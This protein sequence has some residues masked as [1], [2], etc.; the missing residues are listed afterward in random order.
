MPKGRFIPLAM[1]IRECSSANAVGKQQVDY[2]NL[3]C[4]MLIQDL[5]KI[6][7]GYEPYP[8]QIRLAN[9]PD[10][11]E[12]L[13]VPTGVGK[14]AATVLT[15]LYRRKFA[16][17]VTR[18]NTPRRLVYCLP[19]R[20]LVE[21]TRD[22][23]AKWIEN[24]ELS[25]K[26]NLGVGVHI[27]L[28]GS[29][30]GDWYEHPEREGILIGTQDMLL[31]RCLNRGYGMSRYLWPV[32]FALLNN[33]CLWVMDETQLMGV[34]LTTSAQ[35]AG[36]RKK[37]RTFGQHHTLWMSATL[38]AKPIVTVDHPLP[39]G[40][41]WKSETIQDDDRKHERV[42]RLL[43][44]AK[45]CEQAEVTL[46]PDNKAG[47]EKQLAELIHAKHVSGTLT[48][49]VMNRVSRAQQVY[50]LLNKIFEKSKSECPEL[51][52][53][54]SR[55]RKA[56]RDLI[57][58]RALDESTIS[59]EGPGRVIIAT[60]AIEA[61]VDVSAT[62]L[63]TELAPWP[64]LVQRFGRC[65]RR[66]SCAVG[67]NAPAQV[68]WVDIDTSDPKK[69]A[70]NALPYE[71]ADLDSARQTIKLLADVGPGAISKV[72]LETSAKFVH[73]LRRKD[74]LEL[75]DTTTDLSGN[76][77]DVSRY[78]RDGDQSDVQVYWRDWDVKSDGPPEPF[79]SDSEIQFPA[80]TRD[81][82]C[83]VSVASL[84]GNTGFIKKAKDKD[85][86]AYRWNS[87]EKE[88]D[89]VAA[90]S[91]RPGMTL[92]FHSKA[93]GYT[94][95]L[96]W[97]G[98]VKDGPVREIQPSDSYVDDAVDLENTSAAPLT[99]EEHLRFVGA[100]AEFLR[101]SLQMD[102][103]D[104][105]WAAVVRAAWWHDVGKAHPAF[106]GAMLS[107]NHSLSSSEL[108]AKSGKQGYL[109]YQISLGAEAAESDVT[110][111]VTASNRSGLRHELASALAWLQQYPAEENADLIGYLIAAHHGK[112]RMSIR[113][114]PNEERPDD[115]SKLFARG[116]W[117]GDRLPSI[118]IGNREGDCSHEI[119]L[120]LEL[121]KLGESKNGPSWLARS[122]ALRDQF[123]PF[124]LA[125]LETL[126]RVADWRGSAQG[127]RS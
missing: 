107:M 85:Y 19:M 11:P 37:L 81:E 106:Q 123:G 114:M 105:P 116:I 12:L 7:A 61:G 15:W 34:G 118:K 35:L 31:S 76:D 38:D 1:R 5:Y 21:Q 93:G 27:L 39:E 102:F 74:L 91:V 51:E 50:A 100:N 78:I 124:R 10:L 17:E 33:D 60:Q 47:Y 113:S 56:D 99:I 82:L 24:I 104:I 40:G 68:I 48:L 58:Q 72:Q 67:G 84:R 110:T 20:T 26:Q 2:Q 30:A 52:L 64:S 96:G 43:T 4:I 79:N 119:E 77:L 122:I 127:D 46:T 73:V 88:W 95:S 121:M 97:T 9:A 25:T 49:V 23:T 111:M 87:L 115:C 70:I 18:K 36:L 90:N 71:V 14:T 16:T 83:A 75:F 89:V 42:A 69:S 6:A 45:P 126:V 28:G 55:F 53:I 44:A 108:W 109:R 65:N 112:V 63:I 103:P 80:P 8:Y 54:H 117:E 98:E 101:G 125:F 29:D 94:P 13:S 57:Q 120:S 32:D 59:K 41:S 66:G 86:L 62:T 22:V 92:L 3:G